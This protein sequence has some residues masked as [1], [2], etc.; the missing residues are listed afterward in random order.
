MTADTGARPTEPITPLLGDWLSTEGRSSPGIARL[1]VREHDG[2]VWVRAIGG[3]SRDWGEVPAVLYTTLGVPASALT[4]VFDLGFVRTV[5]SAHHKGGILVVTTSNV[6][7][8]GSSR[9]DYWTRE[10]FHR[11]GEQS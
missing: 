8:D 1:E 2:A 4:A 11:I 9:A 5:V 10:F 7:Q 3:G 6:F